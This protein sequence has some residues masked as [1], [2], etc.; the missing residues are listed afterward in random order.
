[1]YTPST[2]QQYKPL[3]VGV[4]TDRELR[5]FF[6]ETMSEYQAI[7]LQVLFSSKS[8]WKSKANAELDY[9][10]SDFLMTSCECYHSENGF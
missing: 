1:M 7:V 3:F 4:A 9:F 2:A 5:L 10:I 6:V 8:R